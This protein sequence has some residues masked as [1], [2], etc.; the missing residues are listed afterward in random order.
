M[1]IAQKSIW[2]Q[3]KF[4]FKWWAYIRREAYIQ[5]AYIREEKHFNLQSVKLTF[6]SILKFK[7]H[8]FGIF[9]IV[10]DVKYVQSHNKDTRIQKGNEGGTR[11]TT[12]TQGLKLKIF[13]PED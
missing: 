9:S 6:I 3:G 12:W 10:Q 1:C 5:G 8:I 2:R 4:K 11:E 13:L 7:E